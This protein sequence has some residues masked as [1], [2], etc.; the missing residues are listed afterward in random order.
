MTGDAIR[1]VQAVEWT[2]SE[3]YDTGYARTPADAA[4]DL[5]QHREDY[6]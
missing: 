2:C 3:C 1:Y 6:H 5:G 4:E